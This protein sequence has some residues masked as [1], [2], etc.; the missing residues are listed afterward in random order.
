MK[1][2]LLRV[3]AVFAKIRFRKF[4]QPQ[5]RDFPFP[6]KILLFQNPP[7]P[8]VDWKSAQSFVGKEHYTIGNLHSHTGQRTQ[9]LSEIGIGQS[10]PCFQARL[11]RAD[12]SR[13]HEQVPGAIA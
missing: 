13:R 12:E 10:R 2:V 1:Q 5:F 7:D 3:T 9:F 11:A 4:P 8:D 6:R